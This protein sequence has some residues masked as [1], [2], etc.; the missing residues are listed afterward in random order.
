[1]Q[2]LNRL[3]MELSNQEYFT[4]EQYTQFLT[5]SRKC[6]NL[7]ITPHVCRH[8]YCSHCASGGMNPKYLQYLMGHSDISVT[9][10][11]YTHVDF[12]NVK[13]EVQSLEKAVL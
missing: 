4:D 10:N 1:M 5:K 9:L 11:T 3:K 8:T 13:K 2:V 7:K 12:D 6:H